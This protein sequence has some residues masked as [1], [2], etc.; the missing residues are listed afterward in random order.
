MSAPYYQYPPS[1]WPPAGPIYQQSPTP[2]GN[3][4]NSMASMTLAG[5]ANQHPPP[6]YG[7][8]QQTSA[9]DNVSAYPL[10]TQQ[11]YAP[12]VAPTSSYG[13]VPQPY[14]ASPM[15]YQT[16]NSA[17]SPQTNTVPQNHA[18]QVYQQ[19][20]YTQT[21]S[22]PYLVSTTSIQPSPNSGYNISTIAPTSTPGRAAPTVNHPPSNYGVQY[23]T[24]YNAAVSAAPASQQPAS[25]VQAS[26]EQ[27]QHSG[28]SADKGKGVQRRIGE[29]RY[30]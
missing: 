29:E 3:L 5:G 23:P 4:S 9:R 20:G 7:A 19:S 21:S 30:S 2:D 16:T 22:S 10:Q 18:H 24:Q 26:T 8:S 13:A 1:T 27:Q 15:P 25:Y 6:N 28:D 14:G 17:S 11:N 12:S